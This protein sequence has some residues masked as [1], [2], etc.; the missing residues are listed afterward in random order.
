MP[1][2]FTKQFQGLEFAWLNVPPP[3][4]K[5]LYWGPKEWHEHRRAAHTSSFIAMGLLVKLIGK[6]EDSERLLSDFVRPSTA[7]GLNE[8][9][10]HILTQTKQTCSRSHTEKW[11]CAVLSSRNDL[12]KSVGVDIESWNRKIKPGIRK[13]YDNML[14]QTKSLQPIEIWCLKE[15]I[16]KAVSSYL[17]FHKLKHSTFVLTDIKIDA[18]IEGAAIFSVHSYSGRCGILPD[19]YGPSELCT[20]WAILSR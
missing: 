18:S 15:A 8:D 17:N 10:Y 20:A 3:I 19:E 12:Y 9:S 14:D 13:F 5:D 7:Q 4:P 2:S 6:T 16:F 11:A 1:Y